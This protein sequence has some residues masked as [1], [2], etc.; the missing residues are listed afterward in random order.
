MKDYVR[1]RRQSTGDAV[2][3]LHPRQTPAQINFGEA[4]IEAPGQ[5]EKIAFLCLILLHSDVWF[6]KARP[7]KTIG[8]FL[9]GLVSAFTFL[10]RPAI[11][12]P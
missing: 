10:K 11:D 1:A 8:A 4:T 9:H 2:V 6:M 5:H 12:P 3:P 7:G